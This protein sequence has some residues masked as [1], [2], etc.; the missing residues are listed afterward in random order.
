MCLMTIGSCLLHAHLLPTLP[1]H[2]APGVPIRSPLVHPQP[3]YVIL[4]YELVKPDGHMA[5]YIAIY[6]S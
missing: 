3:G 4:A 1:C 6:E 5:S 2:C